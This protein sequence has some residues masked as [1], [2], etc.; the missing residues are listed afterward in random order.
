MLV[1]PVTSIF[2]VWLCGLSCQA[3][4]VLFWPWQ[5]AALLLTLLTVQI[6]KAVLRRWSPFFFLVFPW[7]IWKLS[8]SLLD[9]KICT[10][11]S[12]FSFPLYKPHPCSGLHDF[13][14]EKIFLRNSFLLKCCIAFPAYQSQKKNG[15]WCRNEYSVN[16]NILMTYKSFWNVDILFL[17]YTDCQMD[18][19]EDQEFSGI[20]ITSFFTPDMSVC[21]TICT[22]FPK[23][24]FFTFFTRKYQIESQRWIWQLNNIIY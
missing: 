18:I 9:E 17:F 12:N 16:L 13:T 6:V 1:F 15:N 20:N 4:V 24:L 2:I 10:V 7:T 21:Q 22:Y 5:R 19:F 8:L 3:S 14:Y 11:T 23:C